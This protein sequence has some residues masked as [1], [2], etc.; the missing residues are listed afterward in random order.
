MTRI[1]FHTPTK[2]TTVCGNPGIEQAMKKCVYLILA[3]FCMLL[4]AGC[5]KNSAIDLKPNLNVANDQVIA[6]R[7]FTYVFRLLEKAVTDSSLSAVHHAMIDSAMVSLDSKGRVYTFSFAGSRSADHVARAGVFVATIDSGFFHAGSTIRV[8]FQGYAEDGHKVTGSDSIRCKGPQDG[9]YLYDDII[10]GAVI[11]KDSLHSIHVSAVYRC[12][13]TAVFISPGVKQT[14]ITFGGNAGGA[15]SAGHP[16]TAIITKTLE[17]R[18]NCPWI[19]SGTITL[20]IPGA[21]IPTGTIEF[22]GKTSCNDEISYDFD[23]NTYH[24]WMQEK[25]LGN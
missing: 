16:F 9:Q 25:Y 6:S 14:L 4:A 10:P 20:S 18:E 7:M 21:G 22:M 2:H 13:V 1:T 8:A 17:T 12:A 11:S 15:S 23:G 3:L 24:L 19:S 5:K